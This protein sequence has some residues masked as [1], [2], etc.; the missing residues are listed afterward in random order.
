[1]LIFCGVSVSLFCYDAVFNH[2]ALLM[3]VSRDVPN[4][5]EYDVRQGGDGK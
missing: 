3:F 2:E 4:E 1:M 5:H